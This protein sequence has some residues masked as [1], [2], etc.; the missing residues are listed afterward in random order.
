MN[1]LRRTLVASMLLSPLGALGHRTDQEFSVL[2]PEQPTESPGK[3]EVVEFFWYGCPHCHQFEP[4]LESWV[5]KLA[6]DVEFRRVPAIFSDRWAHDAGIYYAFEAL[7]LTG[8][9]HRPFFDAIHRDR[10]RSDDPK[11]LADWLRKNGADPARFEQTLKSFGVQAR[12]RR[13]KQL[14]V[15]YKLDGVPTLA[16]QGRYTIESGRGFEAMLKTADKLIAETRKT[17]AA[18]R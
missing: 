18:K 12:V 13:A 7:G 1:P 10:L 15:S 5:P 8:K 17:Q 6:P 4:L 2:Q 14:S 3:I 9:L 11:A 16:V